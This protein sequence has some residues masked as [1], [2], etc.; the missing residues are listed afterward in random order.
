MQNKNFIESIKSA[1]HDCL[2]KNKKFCIIGIETSYEKIGFKKNFPKQVFEMPVSELALSGLAVGLASQGFKPF[3]HHGR[4]EFSML[5]FDHIFTQASK[6]NFMFGGDYPCPVSFKISLGRRQG[7]GPQHTEGYHSI[8]LQSNGL[9]IFI[10]STPQEAYDHI[11]IINKLDR[12]SVLLEHR[13]LYLTTQ[14]IKKKNNEK[15][16]AKAY[17]YGESKK[18]LIITYGDGLIDCLLA[19]NILKEYGIEISVLS[20]SKFV[21]E[22]KISN[23][24]LSKILNYKDI[25]FFDTRPFMF[26]PLNSILGLLNTIKQKGKSNFYTISPENK[27]CPASHNEMKKYYPTYNTI[28]KRVLKNERKKIKVKNI[29]N[30]DYLYNFPKLNFDDFESIK[31]KFY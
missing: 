15:N 13:R 3:V 30:N 10:P 8:F 20:I 1:Q 5:A 9:D 23:T 22:N 6:W 24:D 25:I 31:K 27:S 17:V 4:V 26:G 18:K 11:S 29:T 19:K 2:R 7:D 21:G 12:P 14:T 28:I 16:N